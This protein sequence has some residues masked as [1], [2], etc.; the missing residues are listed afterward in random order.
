VAQTHDFDVVIIG[1]G[2]GGSVS[3]MRLSEKG[4]KVAILEMGKRYRNSDFPK[5]NWNIRKYL[6]APVIRCFGIQKI[7]LLKRLM[8]LHGVGVG[9]GSLVYANTLMR[10]EK[11]IFESDLWPSAHNWFDE[12]GPH[13]DTAEKML[14]VVENKMFKDNDLA[15]KTLGEELGCADTFKPTN[16]AVYFGEPD[17]QVKDPYFDGKGPDRKG[18][19]G[20]GSCMIGCPNGAK[21]TLDKNY[22]YFAEKRGAQIFAETKANKISK[23][24]DGYEIE[25]LRSTSLFKASAG[26][27]KAKKVIFAAGVLGTTELLLRNREI[28]MSLPHLSK[29]LGKHIRTNGE[30]LLGVTSFDK[31]KDY[32]KGI[33]IGAIIHPNEHTSIE[34]VRYPARSDFLRLMVVPLTGAGNLVTRPLKMLV[35]FVLRFFRILRLLT[36]WDW[37]R[38]T[39]ILL[40]MQSLDNKMNLRLGRSVFSGFRKSLKGEAE[41]EPVPTYLPIAQKAAQVLAKKLNA[42]PTNVASEVLLGTTSTA[43]ILGGAAIGSSSETGVVDSNHEVFGYP[44]LYV[45]DGSVIPANLAVNPSLTITAMAERFSQQFPESVIPG[46]DPGSRKL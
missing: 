41:G 24:E 32:S 23:A 45:C 27:F 35:A 1:S 40:V 18:C 2:F 43:H 42:E 30:S 38:S 44:G 29:N 10:P 34:G 4:Y 9:G 16:V 22:L 13:Y 14:G 15:I 25:T 5:S 31:S 12:L 11:K 20:C 37:A 21:N 33:A 26:T 19:T 17:K 39:V 3:A 28:H 36:L 46:G 8:L 7:T 6:W